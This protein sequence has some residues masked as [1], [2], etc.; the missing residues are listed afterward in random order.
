MT[1][2]SDWE[3]EFDDQFMPKAHQVG[4]IGAMAAPMT[5]LMLAVKVFVRKIVANEGALA[6]D[7]GITFGKASALEEARKTI[8]D[9][10][11]EA[12]SHTYTFGEPIS[13]TTAQ[14]EEILNKAHNQSKAS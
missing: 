7:D 6:F 12:I 10:F 1:D 14:I 9:A 2:T 4:L 8:K 5:E 3:K 11:A 13:W